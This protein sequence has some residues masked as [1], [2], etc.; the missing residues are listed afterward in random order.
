MLR[1]GY[2]LSHCLITKTK[3]SHRLLILIWNIFSLNHVR[4][5]F[6]RTSTNS[7]IMLASTIFHRHDFLLKFEH[8]LEITRS[9][10]LSY[11]R[12]ISLHSRFDYSDSGKRNTFQ[13]RVRKLARKIT[14]RVTKPLSL[15]SF[16]FF[17]F[18]SWMG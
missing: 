6:T 13:V 7:C 1:S 8:S 10:S 11:P 17:L 3:P 9:Q 18:S 16:F 15:F 12:L 2:R 14:H 4:G 5:Q